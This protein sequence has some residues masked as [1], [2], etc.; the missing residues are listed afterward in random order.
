MLPA[1]EYLN[2]GTWSPRRSV[3]YRRSVLNVAYCFSVAS[4]STAGFKRRSNRYP[5]HFLSLGLCSQFPWRTQG[6]ESHHFC[7]GRNKPMRAHVWTCYRMHQSAIVLVRCVPGSSPDDPPFWKSLRRR[8]SG[9]GWSTGPQFFFT[10]KIELTRKE[11]QQVRITKH[12]YK[13]CTKPNTKVHCVFREISFW[14]LARTIIKRM[15]Y[16]EKEPGQCGFKVTRLQM[17]KKHGL[18]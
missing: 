17:R 18:K 5:F 9:W 16:F 15:V 4:N 12:S 11:K 13:K 1:A 8:P 2:W 7:F 3:N 14:Y 10:V 6:A